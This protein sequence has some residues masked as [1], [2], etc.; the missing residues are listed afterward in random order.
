MSKGDCISRE[1]VSDALRVIAC[2]DDHLKSVMYEVIDI[3][4]TIPEKPDVVEIVRC[5]KCKKWHDSHKGD[6]YGVCDYLTS[7]TAADTDIETHKSWN[8][9]KSKEGEHERV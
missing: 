9:A 3:I 5:E 1:G 8:C 4:E 2:E 7:L 6:G